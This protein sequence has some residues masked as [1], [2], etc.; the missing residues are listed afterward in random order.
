M[1][2]APHPPGTVAWHRQGIEAGVL[3]LARCQV[4]QAHHYYPSIVCRACGSDKLAA[5]EASGRGTVYASTV[6]AGDP[7]FSVAIVELAEGPRVLTTLAVPDLPIDAPVELFF[8]DGS[9]G[10]R[11]C[12]RTAP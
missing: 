12:F 1:S 2:A 11:P 4:C 3:L 9:Q 6:N 10:R 7:G 5:V 8:D